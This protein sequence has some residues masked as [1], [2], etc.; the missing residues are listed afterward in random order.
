MDKMTMVLNKHRWYS[1]LT[2]FNY[3]S[4]PTF[5]LNLMIIVCEIRATFLRILLIKLYAFDYLLVL[6]QSS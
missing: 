1:K 4:K 3:Q 5:Q 6:L 2:N